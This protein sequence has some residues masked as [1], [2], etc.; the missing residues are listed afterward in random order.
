MKRVLVLC[1]A[2]WIVAGAA[3]AEPHEQLL[4]GPEGKWPAR[5][6][7]R[8]TFHTAGRPDASP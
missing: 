5:R 8:T 2:G 3:G 1:L 7:T 4:A 6:R